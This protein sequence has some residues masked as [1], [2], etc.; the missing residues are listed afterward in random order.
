MC[1]ICKTPTN[2]NPFLCDACA[3]REWGAIKIG[4]KTKNEG[5]K[6]K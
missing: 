2:R 6:R 5:D 3:D 1:P 4:P